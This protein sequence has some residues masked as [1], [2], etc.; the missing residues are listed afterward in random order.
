MCKQNLKT[1]ILKK[2]VCLIQDNP[3]TSPAPPKPTGGSN[4][5][6]TPDVEGDK[7]PVIIISNYLYS[8]EYNSDGLDNRLT[9]TQNFIILPIQKLK[10]FIFAGKKFIKLF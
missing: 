7:K 8:V 3:P 9:G 5:K 10:I 6:P 1:K 4:S 2:N